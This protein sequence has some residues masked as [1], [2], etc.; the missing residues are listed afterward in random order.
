M[1]S[2]S[3]LLPRNNSVPSILRPL[4]AYH[5]TDSKTLMPLEIRDQPLIDKSVTDAPFSN[6]P[7]VFA[8]A[9]IAAL[10]PA[11]VKPS[12]A[13]RPPRRCP[14]QVK[15]DTAKVTL[16]RRLVPIRKQLNV[17]RRSDADKFL[18]PKTVPQA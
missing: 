10:R 6:N 15:L 8:L 12:S 18:L 2:P 5:T 7:Q 11:A 1:R 3:S 17:E 9:P 16:D 14:F 13:S 4:N